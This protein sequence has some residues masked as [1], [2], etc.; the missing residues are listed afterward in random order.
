MKIENEKMNNESFEKS[1]QSLKGA[2]LDSSIKEAMKNQILATD[3]SVESSPKRN[4][5]TKAKKAIA[6][7]VIFVF[8]FGGVAFAST[9]SLPGEVLYSIK[10]K[11]VEPIFASVQIGGQAKADYQFALAEKRVKEAEILNESG[12]LDNLTKL[13]LKNS[14]ENHIAVASGYDLTKKTGVRAMLPVIFQDE[15][16]N[17]KKENQF[18]IDPKLKVT[19]TSVIE[20]TTGSTGLKIDI[21]LNS[22]SQADII[23]NQTEKLIEKTEE[24]KDTVEK[25]LEDVVDTVEKI[26]TELD[27][28]IDIKKETEISL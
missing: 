26:N 7:G 8:G 24:I 19:A 3:L 25:E 18:V 20:T 9:D 27:I 4:F 22:S 12:S 28:D 2:S 23:E 11:I 10:T 21:N 14:F 17:D 13:E 16:S 5:A 15:T 1:L 6:T